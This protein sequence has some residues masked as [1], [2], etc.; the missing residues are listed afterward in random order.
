[1]NKPITRAKAIYTSEL[2]LYLSAGWETEGEPFVAPRS[3]RQM[4]M[5]IHRAD[6]GEPPE[7]PTL[8]AGKLDKR[9]S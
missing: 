7:S 9:I 2:E 3:K 8:C 5:V 4:V 1:M 6:P